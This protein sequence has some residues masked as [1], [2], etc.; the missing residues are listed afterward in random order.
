VARTTDRDATAATRRTGGADLARLVHVTP[1]LWWALILSLSALV[2]FATLPGR[3]LI[4]HTLQKLAH[5]CVFGLIGVSA[6]VLLRQ[7]APDAGRVWLQYTIA[8]VMAVV[9][10]S[11]TEA[12]QILTHRDPSW[13]DIGLDARGAACA[14]ALAATFDVRARETP[15]GPRLRM[16]Y[17]VVAIAL[18]ALIL[19]PLCIT[20][21]GYQNRANR[22]PVLLSAD[23][24]IDL[25][26]ASTAGTPITRIRVPAPVA[27]T[28]VEYAV[29]VPFNVHGIAGVSIDEPEPDWRAYH[30]LLIDLTNPGRVPLDLSLRIQ[31]RLHHAS[32]ADR[33]VAV[34]SLAAGERRRFAIDLEAIR[35]APVERPIDLG[36]IGTI[37]LN[38]V[39]NTGER[40]FWLNRAELR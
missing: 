2:V 18:A 34:L 30:Q 13:R 11:L 33:F 32:D 16:L 23:H 15:R 14:L 37:T 12:A 5:P 25:L 4:Y 7:R 6:L 26:F 28:D 1:V 20:L 40:E 39:A 21:A 29:R 31:D 19:T 35:F 10:G 27:R 17:A 22:F 24:T 36:Q 9:I 8:L 3:P 38:R